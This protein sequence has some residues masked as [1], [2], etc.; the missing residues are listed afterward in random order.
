MEKED[1]VFRKFFEM[2]LETSHSIR[3]CPPK[4]IINVQTYSIDFEKHKKTCKQCRE[5]TA[6]D[7]SSSAWKLIVQKANILN[8]QLGIDAPPEIGEIY[9]LNDLG[10]LDVSGRVQYING[11]LVVLT[12]VIDDNSFRAALVYHDFTMATRDDFKIEYDVDYRF[13]L[14]IQGWNNF[15]I[16]KNDLGAKF[17]AVNQDL[18]DLLIA[19]KNKSDIVPASAPTFSEAKEL[20]L[21]DPR[22]KFMLESIELSFLYAKRSVENFFSNEEKITSRRPSYLRVVK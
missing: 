12:E 2:G 10:W 1:M 6:E 15:P 17:G 3:F 11:P 21:E 8:K 7:A 22:R 14:L 16:L 20:T 4:E 9:F 19:Q 18:I 5:Q 13:K